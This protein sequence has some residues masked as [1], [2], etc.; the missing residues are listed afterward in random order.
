M[1][2][3]WKPDGRPESAVSGE[4]KLTVIRK[5]R[6]L[7][8]LSTHVGPSSIVLST[9]GIVVSLFLPLKVSAVDLYVAV[10]GGDGNAGT[11]AAPLKTLAKAQAQVRTLLPD[12]SG[13]INVWI[14]GGTWGSWP[15]C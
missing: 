4:C 2:F 14:R 7:N 1:S 13:P 6:R 12:A 5:Q 10:N 11:I 15:T 8:T 3:C 9:V